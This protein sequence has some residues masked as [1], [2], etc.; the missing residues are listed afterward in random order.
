MVDIQCNIQ[1]IRTMDI[2][3]SSLELKLVLNNTV[4]MRSWSDSDMSH[5]S[6]SGTQ[7]ADY[8]PH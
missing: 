7:C 4:L 8:E 3:I 1:P 6:P 2:N 5:R